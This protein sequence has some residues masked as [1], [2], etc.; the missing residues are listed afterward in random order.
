MRELSA[1]LSRIDGKGYK[2][3]K[4]LQG[5]TF[6]FDEFDLIF[7]YVQGDPFASPSMVAVRM[8]QEKASFPQ[9]SFRG[10]VRKRAA[11]DHITRSLCRVLNRNAGKRKGSGK[12]GMLQ[13]DGPG[14]EVLERTSVNITKEFVEA[15]ISAGLPAF[16]RRI[17]GQ[18]ARIMFFDELPELIR[19]GMKF[20][21]LDSRSYWKHVHS[22]EDQDFLRKNLPSRGLVAF[23]ADGSVL[24][25][26]SG[27]DQGPLLS[28]K[29]VAFRSPASLRIRM[30][31]PNGGTVEGMG[32]PEGITLIAGGGYHGKSTFLRALERGVYDHI[33]GDG[34]ERVVS[35]PG[36][37]K[38]RAEDGR[39]VEKVNISP[40]IN[41]LPLEKDTKEFSTDE[42]SGSTSQA[43]NIVEAVEAGTD[44]LLLDEDTSA[45]NF[46]IRDT[47]MQRLV[48][49]D[50]EPITPF[51]DKV[52]QL[53]TE[54]F[55]S[56]VIVMGGSGDY[57]DVADRVIMMKDFLP[58]DVTEEARTIAFENGTGRM[59]EGGA[60]FGEISPRMPRP[61]SL[62]PRKGKKVKIRARGNENIQFGHENIKMDLVEQIVDRSQTRAIGD[63]IHYALRAGI[64]DGYSSIS[65]IIARME[66]ILDEKGIDEIS[67]FG[68]RPV[69]NHAR[70]RTMEMAAALNRLRTL[71]VKQRSI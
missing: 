4:E 2:A 41:N 35:L 30:N 50:K 49:K 67:P 27:I 24:P 44:L 70:P 29:A 60:S 25:R 56:T 36:A 53:Y 34:R 11:A 10:S 47:R 55:I 68:K 59:V 37:V 1:I 54:K 63:M 48:A 26:K 3:Y 21:N 33:P 42:A 39:R 15:R 6:H 62:D 19:R 16:G 31:T 23:I 52:R 9:D 22:V 58:E 71:K 61:E 65:E 12:S 38:I 32:I 69:G 43:A 40:F 45:T 17:A 14:Q 13:I 57:F 64:I 5:K 46:M 20:E 51:V 7:H 8:S 18:K 28:K 66:D